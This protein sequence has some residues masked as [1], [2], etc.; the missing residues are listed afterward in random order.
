MHTSAVNEATTGTRQIILGCDGTNNTLTGGLHD[1]N[2]LKLIGQLG[3][4][5]ARRILYYDPGVG[6]PDQVPSIGVINE[7][8]RRWER[9]AGLA[10]GRGV[11]ENIAEAYLF[12]V[13]HYRP[14]D[15][16]FIFGFSRGAFTARSVAGMVRLFG[17]VSADSKSLILTLI[18]VYFATPTEQ[19]AQLG[20]WSRFLHNRLL[21]QQKHNTVL[22]DMTKIASPEATEQD[23]RRY[24]ANIK[25]R[26]STREEVADQVRAQFAFNGNADAVIHFIGVWDTVESVGILGLRRTITSYRTVQHDPHLRHIR[27]ALSMDEH[28]LAFAPRLYWDNDYDVPSTDPA[29]RRSLR[30]RWF[31]GVHSDVGGG[32]HRNEAGL[33]DQAYQ[34]MLDEAIACDLDLKQAVPPP[35]TKPL[36]THDACRDTPWWG[37]AGLT[38]RSNVMHREGEADHRVDVVTQAAASEANPRIVSVWDAVPKATILQALWALACVAVL[39]CCY[40]WLASMAIVGVDGTNVWARI[41]P[42][43]AKLEM[44]QKSY[45]LGWFTGGV[46][47]GPTL[48]AVRPAALAMAVDFGL[49]VAYSWLVGLLASWSFHLVVGRRDPAAK[50]PRMARLGRAPMFLVLADIAE[51]LFTLLTLWCIA[52]ALDRWSYFFGAFMM[53]AGAVK[54]ACLLDTLALFAGGLATKASALFALRKRIRSTPGPT[55]GGPGLSP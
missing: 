12:L 26:R 3:P 39:L 17:I 2:V 23:I 10:N 19:P 18:R 28:R 5:T 43:V 48:L 15:Q 16:V 6:S 44:W 24:L 30:Q 34:W 31:R 54:W 40:G 20:L 38:V 46:D 25:Q 41:A 27:Q 42:G 1:T 51:N 36:I 45:F 35:Q 33:S 14:G 11:Y 8:R 22:E 7:L 55:P 37:V 47:V 53:L 4:E 52:H 49:I 50:P 21:R 9:I 32:Y 13:D 29:G